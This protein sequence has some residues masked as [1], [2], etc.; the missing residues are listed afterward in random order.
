MLLC[1]KVGRLLL[2]CT[3]EELSF[4]LVVIVVLEYQ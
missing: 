1:R 2:D 4:A 3:V